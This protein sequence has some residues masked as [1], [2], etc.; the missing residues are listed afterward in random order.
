[1]LSSK[2]VF[3]HYPI[4]ANLPEVNLC[5]D[6]A[7]H[8]AKKRAI[9]AAAKARELLTSAGLRTTP[10]RIAVIRWLQ[11][12]K[13]PAT[14]THIA[15]E[16]VPLGFD[17]ATIFRALNDLVKSNLVARMELGDHVWRFELRDWSDSGPSNHPHFVCVECGRITCLPDGDLLELT[18]KSLAKLG[19]MT[20]VI[21][22][23]HCVSCS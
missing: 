11:K 23:G 20:E 17:R 8:V 10:A 21:V 9:E 16:L 1:M 3:L 5:I 4:R 2:S 15:A 19:E 12:S 22:R 6:G 13:T 14:H 7:W 18:Q